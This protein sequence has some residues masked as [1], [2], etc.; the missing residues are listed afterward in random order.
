MLT[1]LTAGES[2]G[3]G[4]FAFLQGIPANLKIDKEF[5]N[6][7]LKRRQGGYG[8]GGRQK[9]EKDKVDFLAGVREGK[10]LPGPILMAVWNK[11]FENWKDIMSPFCKVPEDKKITRPRP[12]H[13]DLVGTL[14]Y[15]QDD[16]RNILERASARETAGRVLAGSICKLFLKEVDIEIFSYVLQIGE[17]NILDI[18]KAILEN[19]EIDFSYKNVK[20]AFKK[21]DKTKLEN[22]LKNVFN[23]S[24]EDFVKNFNNISPEKKHLEAEKSEFR[25]PIHLKDIENLYKT[26]IDTL[27]ESGET[28]GGYFEVIATNLPIGLGSHIQ[29]KERLNAKLAYHIMSIQAFKGFE[30]GL[31]KEFAFRRGSQAM[32]SIYYDEEKGFYRKTNYSGG[33]EGGMTTGENLLFRATIKPIPTLL[34][35]LDSINIK[36][37]EPQKAIYERSDVCVLPA[38]SVV[39]E[40]MTA[41]CLADELLSFVPADNIE[42]FKLF[43]KMKKERLKKGKF[44][45]ENE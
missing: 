2:H 15:N 28:I 1:F 20:E 23:C 5:I 11:D 3:K 34:K 7:E 10:T 13:A 43:Y 22:Y 36:T 39:A 37:K 17:L 21:I 45:K 30:I 9:I 26:Y 12:G 25:L 24:L 33:L 38:A 16:I 6:K 40:H 8:R 44:L 35:P 18:L 14:K 41:I 29:W 19:R 4:V 27:K 32:D 31:G 42:E